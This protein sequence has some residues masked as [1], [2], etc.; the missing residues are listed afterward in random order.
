MEEVKA[1]YL[2]TTKD[3]QYTAL[4]TSVADDSI[5]E[6]LEVEYYLLQPQCFSSKKYFLENFNMEELD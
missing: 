2:Y 3:K 4:V 6:D 1:G 5:I